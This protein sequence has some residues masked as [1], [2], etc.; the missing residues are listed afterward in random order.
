MDYSRRVV[1]KV[2]KLANQLVHIYRDK[3]EWH[4]RRFDQILLQKRNH[5]KLH[6]GVCKEGFDF[7]VV[8]S[9]CKEVNANRG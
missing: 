6:Q 1:F 2:E 7:T 9:Y 8:S 4:P 3:Y 5:G